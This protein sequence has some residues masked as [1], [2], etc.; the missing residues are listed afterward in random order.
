LKTLQFCNPSDGEG[1]IDK[2]TH[3]MVRGR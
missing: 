1:Q 3:L 2:E